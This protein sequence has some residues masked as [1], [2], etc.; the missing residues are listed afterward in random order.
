MPRC[1]S[2]AVALRVGLVASPG[3]E[4]YRDFLGQL[5]GSGFGFHVQVVPVAVQGAN[6]PSAVAGGGDRLVPNRL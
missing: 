4:G 1:Q 5:T 3:T 6:A 2:P